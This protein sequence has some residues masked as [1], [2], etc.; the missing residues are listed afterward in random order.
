[1]EGDQIM[2]RAFVTGGNG[3]LHSSQNLQRFVVN[4]SPLK[5]H[6]KLTSRSHS[7]WGPLPTPFPSDAHVPGSR[8]SRPTLREVFQTE[9]VFLVMLATNSF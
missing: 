1:M 5:K 2:M 6:D 3:E 8:L 4:S 7:F 9:G